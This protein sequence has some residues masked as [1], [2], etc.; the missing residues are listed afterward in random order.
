MRSGEAG[1]GAGNPLLACPPALPAPHSPCLHLKPF[2]RYGG[3]SLAGRDPDLPSGREVAHTVAEMRALMTPEPGSA[4]DHILNNL[5]QWALGLDAQSSLKVGVGAGRWGRPGD[6]R[7]FASL[8]SWSLLHSDLVQQQ[9][10]A[11]HGGL[12]EPSQQWT[13]TCP[14][15]VCHSPP[16]P[17]HHYAQP[18]SEPDQGAAV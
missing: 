15:T 8:H 16:C 11:C 6:P 1:P 17:Q 9:G 18:S 7:P 10:L 12:R 3:F 13:P 14:P 5:T 4:L 2:P